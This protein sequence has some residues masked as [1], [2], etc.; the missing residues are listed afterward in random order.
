MLFIYICVLFLAPQLWVE[1]FAGLRPDLVIYPVWFLACL[2]SDR[3]K[4]L[5][6]LS[7]PDKCFLLLIIWIVLSNYVNGGSA[8]FPEIIFNYAKW[9]VLFKLTAASIYDLDKL[10]T[11]TNY[12]VVFA[13]VLAFESIQ[14]KL[15]IGGTGW[16]GQ[17]LAWVQQSVID[18]G[19]TGRTRWIGIFDGPGTF[20][21]IFTIALP[22]LLKYFNPCYALREKILAALLI[23]PL[24]MAIYYTGSRGGFLATL[25]ILGIFFALKLKIS[26]SRITLITSLLAIVFML[27]PSSLT[28]MS[29]KEKSAQHRVDMWGEG[30]EMFQQ[31][32]VFG[33]GRGNFLDYTGKLLA[34]NSAIELMGELGFPG[35]FFWAAMIYMVLKYL[36]KY[37]H[38]TSD[39][40]EKVN[41]QAVS[42]SIMGYL[43]SAM[44]VTLEYETQYFIL[45]I[46]A[47]LSNKLDGNTAIQNID[48]KYIV[49]GIIAWYLFLKVFLMFLWN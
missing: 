29:D 37:Y 34:H 41:V 19:G 11:V 3:A 9:F 30:V 24:I 8:R 12:I 48:K 35:I 1:S 21:V 44:F 20:C 32:P 47:S 27:A 36:Y 22:F 33:I 42:L 5:F 15:S 40:K 13:L 17:S 4:Y 28:T 14:H 7:S 6:H 10:K 45:G 23:L 16:A 38:Q 2:L 39:I 31:N 49:L 43:A 18:S 46:A 25:A 26:I